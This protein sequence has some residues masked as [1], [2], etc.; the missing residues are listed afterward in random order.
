MGEGDGDGDGNEAFLK[1]D[2]KAKVEKKSE[3]RL[4]V[5]VCEL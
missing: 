3:R 1:R 2:G 5:D 4:R